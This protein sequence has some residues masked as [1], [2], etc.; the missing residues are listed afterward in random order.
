MCCSH[1][2][3]TL[4]ALGM[5]ALL[6]SSVAEAQWVMLARRAVGRVEQMSQTA[7]ATGATY[8]TAAVIVEVPA[9]KV[10][11]TVKRSVLAAGSTQGITVTREDDARMSLEFSR[12]TQ[13]AGIQV[14]SLGDN[15]THLM[16]SSAHP[17]IPASPT[18]MI[19][20]RIMAICDDLRIPC[21][22]AQQ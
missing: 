16:I 22:R 8:D 18:S 10:Y 2:R 3:S 7:P 12:G 4:V 9:D 14:N 15:L 1:V 21:Q 5:A 13:L 6:V 20:E 19:V 11:A 17:G